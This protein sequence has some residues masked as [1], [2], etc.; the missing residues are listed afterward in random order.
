M[1]LSIL[2]FVEPGLSRRREI[3]R[4]RPRVRGAVGGGDPW[5]AVLD[6]LTSIPTELYPLG[7]IFA[8]IVHVFHNLITKIVSKIHHDT[9]HLP[10]TSGSYNRKFQLH[11]VALGTY[12]RSTISPS[13]TGQEDQLRTRACACSV[14]SRYARSNGP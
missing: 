14:T 4:T 12:P 3:G 10:G 1:R 6:I 8:D 5:I 11:P 13:S 7:I 9:A 2:G